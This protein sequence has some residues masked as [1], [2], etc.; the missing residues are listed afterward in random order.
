MDTV[1]NNML[2]DLNSLYAEMG[3]RAVTDTDDTHSHLNEILN[4][5]KPAVAKSFIKTTK[6]GFTVPKNAV[7]SH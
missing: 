7:R 5:L 1:L 4:I 2:L 3:Q 6:I